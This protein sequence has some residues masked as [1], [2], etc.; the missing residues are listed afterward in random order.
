LHALAVD[1]PRRGRLLG[2]AATA[3]R[4]Y[5]EAF[6]GHA[7][8]QT[9]P[10]EIIDAFERDGIDWPLAD[11]LLALGALGGGPR[12]V[13]LDRLRDPRLDRRCW[14]RSRGAAL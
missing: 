9:L 13:T 2:L 8:Y 6:P 10:A 12:R 14:C 4:E 1:H 7:L 5:A 3:L 11:R